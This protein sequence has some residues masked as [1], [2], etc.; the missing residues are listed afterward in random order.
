MEFKQK[1]AE[2][3]ENSVIKEVQEASFFRFSNWK[4]ELP[5]NILKEAWE[6]VDY[7]NIKSEMAKII[8]STLAEKVINMLAQ[9]I[10][11]DLKQLLSNKERREEIRSVART[12]LSHLCNNEKVI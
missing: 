1:L 7:E 10:S 4:S 5:S 9:E 6:M 2:A 12:H 3:I 11:T 8:E